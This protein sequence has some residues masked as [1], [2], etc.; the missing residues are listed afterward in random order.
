MRRLLSIALAVA[1][2]FPAVASVAEAAIGTWLSPAPGQVVSGG[3][4]E[5]AVGF[6][7]QSDLKVTS[8]ELWI[9][10]KLYARKILS[11]PSARGVSSFAWDT[12]RVVKGSHDLVVKIFAKNDLISTVSGVGTVGAPG[13]RPNVVDTR[14]PLVT[15]ANIKSGDVL[16]GKTDV[17][18]NASDD[19]GQ[20]PMVSLLVD[21]VLKLL[22]NTPPYSYSLDTATYEDGDHQ[23]TTYA[24]DNAG[25]RSDPVVVK[26]AFRNGTKR[27]IVAAMTMDTTPRPEPEAAPKLVKP[28]EAPKPALVVPQPVT[29]RVN[30]AGRVPD[31]IKPAPIAVSAVIA[32]VIETGVALAASVSQPPAAAVPGVVAVEV[33]VS[34]VL[35]DGSRAMAQSVASSAVEPLTVGAARQ[36]DVVAA[37]AA[38]APETTLSTDAAIAADTAAAE[39]EV[40]RSPEVSGVQQI[41]TAPDTR[42]RA[43]DRLKVMGFSA[44]TPDVALS[45]PVASD[46]ANVVA[47]KL[48]ERLTTPADRAAVSQKLATPAVPSLQKVQS[49]MLTDADLRAS[50]RAKVNSLPPAFRKEVKARIEKSTI[51]SSGKVRARTLFEKMGGVLLWDPSTHEVTVFVENM[52]IEMEIGSKVARVNGTEMLMDVAPYIADGRTIIDASL[53]HQACALVAHAKMMG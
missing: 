18:I 12:T 6:N 8:L 11:Q 23:L 17:S 7:T 29:P 9:D 35:S 14:A 26:V 53:Y 10:G 34:G 25:N 39:P 45:D 5:V 30:E 41:A 33:P 47:S 22:R 20:S 24:Y 32:P 52:K 36:A 42:L 37:S 40:V 49:A 28:A 1:M 16:K 21:D 38:V 46:V 48:A 31:V 27:P 43:E 4:V 13:S 3:K 50:T 15:F 51:P 44:E 2:V 19:S